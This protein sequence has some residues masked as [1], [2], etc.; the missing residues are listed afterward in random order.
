MVANIHYLT[1][2]ATRPIGSGPRIIAHI[3]NNSRKWGAGF[4]LAVSRRWPEPESI[5][6]KRQTIQL[7]DVDI[8]PVEK[9]LWVANLIAQAGIG[10]Q[11][12]PP[13]RYTA[14]QDCLRF[15]SG[16]AKEFGASIHM[17]RI[18]CGLAG[19]TWD[20]VEPII[21]ETLCDV[22]VYVYDFLEG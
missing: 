13:I 16:Y 7:G 9:D 5:Y 3:C 4:V 14:L 21:S 17:P 15:L 1:G 2:D 12:G 22:E 20:K 11:N 18:G 19:G 6:R 8:V 10:F